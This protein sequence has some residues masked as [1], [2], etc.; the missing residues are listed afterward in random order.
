MFECVGNYFLFG[1]LI[2]EFEEEYS[3]EVG[4]VKIKNE[5][6]DRKRELL[7]K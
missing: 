2:T 1:A 7:E 3:K 5:K 4:W 6:E